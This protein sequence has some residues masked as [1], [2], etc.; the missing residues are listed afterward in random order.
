MRLLPN[1]V[2]LHFLHF[3]FAA[4]DANG[5]GENQSDF[6]HNILQVDSFVI[7]KLNQFQKCPFVLYNLDKISI[8]V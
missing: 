5:F 4:N 1:L 8:K 7:D 2:L 3:T 6:H